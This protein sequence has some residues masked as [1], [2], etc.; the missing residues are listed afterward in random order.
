LKTVETIKP[1]DY[2]ALRD[3]MVSVK[4]AP[5]DRLEKI[6]R[7]FYLYK[8]LVDIGYI[9]KEDTN[10]TKQA[11]LEENKKNFDDF[12]RSLVDMTEGI[13]RTSVKK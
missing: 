11:L 9:K 2:K 5:P 12:A 7:T 6:N 10:V 8:L 13:L 1:T 4:D 3:A